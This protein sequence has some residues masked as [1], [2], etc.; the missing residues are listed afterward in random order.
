MKHQNAKCGYFWNPEIMIRTYNCTRLM[1][2]SER[3]TKINKFSV[4]NLLKSR[5]K[6]GRDDA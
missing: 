3:Q 2:F 4:E 6:K 5:E 1:L